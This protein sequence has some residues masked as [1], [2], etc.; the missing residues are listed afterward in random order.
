[1]KISYVVLLL[2]LL[3]AAG[4]INYGRSYWHPYYVNMKGQKTVDD[5][6]SDIGQAA[7]AKLKQAFDL[8]NFSYPPEKISLI[9]IKDT[10]LMELWAHHG[11]SSKQIKTYPIQAASGVLGPKLRE[12]DFQVPEGIYQINAFNPNSSY[13]LS[14]KLNYP[15]AFDLKYA[16]LEGRTQP[17]S[18]IFIHGKAVSIGCLAMGDEAIEELFT[19]VHKV[20]RANVTV[21]ITPTDPGVSALVVPEGSPDWVELLYEKIE[22]KL[23][24]IKFD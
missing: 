12:G 14:L 2:F 6:I 10:N 22:T 17:G 3:T 15:N 24:Q 23:K 5:V 8:A 4:L 7:D 21:V 18:D 9:A 19:L 20:G 16:A 11:E 1:M 13:H